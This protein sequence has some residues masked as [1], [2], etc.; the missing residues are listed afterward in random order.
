MY[1]IDELAALVPMASD[2]EQTALTKDI[3]KNGQKEPA[4]LWQ[5]RIVDGRCRQLACITLGI[6][7]EVKH[8]DSKLDRQ[9]VALIVKSLNTRRNLTMTQKVMSAV[10]EQESTG[11]SNGDTAKAWAISPATLK[12]AKYIA[13]RCPEYVEPLF[14]GRSVKILDESKGYYTTTNKVNTIA[15]IL[16]KNKEYG[17]IDVDTSE[18][19]EFT[20]DG[21]I[22]TE[23]GKDWYYSTVARYNV[24]DVGLRMVLVEMANL[25][26]RNKEVV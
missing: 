25:K 9:E 7:L 23:E 17:N 2:K 16:K 10:K 20:V 11:M 4:V 18:E 21:A 12:N 15:R 5:D 6:P 1:E 14:D 3:E 19:V 8:L 24:S 13:K 22:K 26:Y